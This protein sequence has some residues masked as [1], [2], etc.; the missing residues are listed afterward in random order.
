VRVLFDATYAE[1]AP[2][3]GTGIY[4]AQVTQALGQLED[5][6]VHLVANP[7]RR[8]PAGGGF[9]SARNLLAD[10]WWTSV[11]LPQLARRS[12]AEVIHHPLPA[13][14]RWTS[15]PQV[16][17]VHDLAFERLP[18]AFDPRF[19]RYAKA[20]HRGAARHAGAVIA[21]SDTTA[22]DARVVWG[23]DPERIV[24]APHGPGQDLQITEHKPTHFL[25]V[26]DEEPRKNLATLLA[27]YATYR[28]RAAEPHELVLAGSVTSTG[29]GIR[30]ERN[31]DPNRLAELYANAVALVHPSLYEGFG[32]TA[33]EAMQAGVPVLASDIRALREVCGGAALYEPPE[34][35]GRFALAMERLTTQPKLRED[36]AERGR[37]RAALYSWERAARTHLEAYALA[38]AR[39]PLGRRRATR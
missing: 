22:L 39:T 27:A 21:V 19:R 14:A 5:I 26:G 35:A 10:R 37:R 33:L 13:F 18:A 6:E 12:K 16:I 34:D 31:P 4:I 36:L 30:A 9:G 23:I 1:R 15:I 25:D 29:D 8:P 32:L 24:V 28:R 20:A 2:Y 11:K 7:S 17:T 38:L 3:S